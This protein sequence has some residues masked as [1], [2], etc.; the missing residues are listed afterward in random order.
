MD[1]NAALREMHQNIMDGAFV[2]ARQNAYD[3]KEWLD[4]KGFSPI[5]LGDQN[6]MMLCEMIIHLVDHIEP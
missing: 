1:P 3:L 5:G 2:D 6:A 4:R